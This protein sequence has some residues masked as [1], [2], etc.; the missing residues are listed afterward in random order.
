MREHRK[1]LR[2]NQTPQEKI[3][4][5]YLKDKRTGHKF[6]RQHSVGGYILDFYC[7]E[8]KLIVEI[9]G[10]IHNTPEAREY[11]QIRDKFFTDLGYKILRFSNDEISK[12]INS[13]IEKIKSW[14]DSYGKSG[15]RKKNERT[16]YLVEKASKVGQRAQ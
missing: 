15:T 5:W 4:W 7:A 13:V 1:E 9:D 8:N 14:Q 2:K 12:D 16:Q 10:R 3:L 6:R 11:D